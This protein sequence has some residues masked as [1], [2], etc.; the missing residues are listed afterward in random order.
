[1]T[2]VTRLVLHLTCFPRVVFLLNL[3]LQA[4]LFCIGIF[5]DIH[6]AAIKRSSQRGVQFLQMLINSR[7]LLIGQVGIVIDAIF[8]ENDRQ[9]TPINKLLANLG[10]QIGPGHIVERGSQAK[11]FVEGAS[12]LS[13]STENS[14]DSRDQG[15]AMAFDNIAVQ[16]CCSFCGHPDTQDA[17][18]IEFV[19]LGHESSRHLQ[20]VFRRRIE[21]Q[22]SHNLDIF[23]QLVQLQSDFVMLLLSQHFAWL[24]HFADLFKMIPYD[25]FTQFARQAI[26]QREF[27][28]TITSGHNRILDSGTQSFLNEAVLVIELT[29]QSFGCR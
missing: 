26:E 7:I 13:S 17:L 10:N 16:C 24:G 15:M 6:A 14:A 19:T 25:T 8:H 2:D 23:Y 9:F 18:R 11:A 5:S 20:I 12:R 4:V 29:K 27:A 21:W 3:V 1:M 28:G 22:I